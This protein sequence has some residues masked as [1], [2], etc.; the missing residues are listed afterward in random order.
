MSALSVQRKQ[1]VETTQLHQRKMVLDSAEYLSTSDLKNQMMPLK[2]LICGAGI[3]GNALAFWLS[4]IGHKITVIEHFPD[5]RATGLQLDLRGPGIQVLRKMGLE[6]TFRRS[7]VKEQGMKLVDKK[8]RSWGYFSAN[9]SGEGLQSLTTDFEIMRGDLC[10]LL[11]DATKVHV[12]YKFGMHAISIEQNTYFA[13]VTFSN[14]A[15]ERFDIVIGAD[16]QGSRT[17]KMMLDSEVTDGTLRADP[18]QT[19]GAFA[20]Y[21]TVQEDIRKDEGYDATMYMTTKSRGIMTRRHDPHKYQAYLFCSTDS[22]ERLKSSK[23]G[24]IIKE[25]EGFKEVFHGTGW[26]S[27]EIL[28]ALE[29]SDDFYCERIGVIVLDHWSPGR[30]ALVGDAAYCPS[31]MTGMGTSCGMTGAYVLAGEI[32]RHYGNQS[33]AGTES[34]AI[35]AAFNSYERK[36]RPLMTQVQ[37]GLTNNPRYMESL[38]SSEWGVGMV[39]VLF[40]FASL[41]RLDVLAR[42][43]LREDTNGWKLPEYPEMVD[44]KRLE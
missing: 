20:G 37:K 26:R 17:R 11:Y 3:T 15:Q 14:G 19:L 31:V 43:V 27:E 35:T 4:K 9:R 39:Y 12:T 1:T 23:K 7:T 28:K 6:E 16:G 36:L 21:F 13:E 32:A 5:L 38:P 42:W 33:K 34:N 24:D 22:S 44:E 18:F 29:T 25:K 30:I 10:R 40:W 2:I 41:L 8:G